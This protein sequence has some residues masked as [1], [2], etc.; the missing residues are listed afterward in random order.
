MPISL[1]ARE[2]QIARGGSILE[3]RL[4]ADY[5]TRSLLRARGERPP[6]LFAI[7]EFR[8][9]DGEG[10]RRAAAREMKPR[11]LQ[12]I[13]NLVDPLLPDAFKVR[14]SEFLES[15]GPLRLDRKIVVAFVKLDD[16]LTIH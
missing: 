14:G 2:S 1:L 15:P 16:A 10:R 5:Q 9:A 3:N 11:R 13:E 8:G 4:K 7:C 12:I 6:E